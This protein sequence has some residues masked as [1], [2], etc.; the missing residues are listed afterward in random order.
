MSI[1][2]KQA[3]DEVENEETGDFRKDKYIYLHICNAFVVWN[4]TVFGNN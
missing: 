4:T 2:A 3:D 1:R